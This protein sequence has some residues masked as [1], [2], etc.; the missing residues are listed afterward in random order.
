MIPQSG[1]NLDT[2]GELFSK[3]LAG[4]NQTLITK[5]ASVQPDGSSGPVSWLTTAFKTLS[6]PVVLPG[7]KFK[8]RIAIKA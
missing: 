6:I 4:E 7:Q 1:S 5:G 3:F 2:I 8:V